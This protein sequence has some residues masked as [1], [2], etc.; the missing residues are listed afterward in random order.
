VTQSNRG[1][2]P[3][4]MTEEAIVPSKDSPSRLPRDPQ[5]HA[6]TLLLR[7]AGGDESALASLYDGWA[8]RVY[9][10]AFWFLQDPDDAADVVGETFWQAWR[11]AGEYDS[12]RAAGTTWLLMIARSRAL[13]RVRAGRRRIAWTTARPTVDTLLEQIAAV[14][15]EMPDAVPEL[16]ESRALIAVRLKALP[17]EQREV[18]EM[19]FFAGL[20]HSEIAEKTAQPLGTVKTRIRLAM[21]KLREGLA[22]L[23]KDDR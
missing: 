11:S 2:Q 23:R 22:S 16:S 13:D 7:M 8:E 9:S 3:Y 21:K 14:Q 12:A 18:V 10:V 17:A 19:A 15:G 20:S 1:M 5:D 6:Q 4:S